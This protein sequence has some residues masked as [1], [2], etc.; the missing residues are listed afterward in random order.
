MKINFIN[1]ALSEEALDSTGK[2]LTNLLTKEEYHTFIGIS[3]FA[4]PAGVNGVINYI[5]NANQHL[6]YFI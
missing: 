2:N 1:Q 3:A 6:K 5:N 4:S